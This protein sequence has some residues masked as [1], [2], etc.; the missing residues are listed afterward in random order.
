MNNSSDANN[1]YKAEVFLIKKNEHDELEKN[2]E[3]IH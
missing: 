2:D 3:I 1:F